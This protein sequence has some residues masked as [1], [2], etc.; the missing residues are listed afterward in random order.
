MRKLLVVMAVGLF[1]FAGIAHADFEGP[2]AP[3]NWTWYDNCFGSGTLTA[4]Q[5]D[6]VGGDAYYAGYSEYQI[7]VPGNA[8]LAFDWS[9]FSY[10]SGT[11][12]FGYYRLNGVQT[13]I[14][15]NNTQGSGSLSVPVAAGD[16]FALGVETMDG[17]YGAGYLTITNFVPEPGSL[18]A[19]LVLAGLALRRR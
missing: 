12:D 16:A 11:Y 17:G 10:D 5:M 2:Y 9:Y 13:V 15:Y 8:T 7:T 1:A 3:A 18:A 4:T 6:V 14:A 19:M